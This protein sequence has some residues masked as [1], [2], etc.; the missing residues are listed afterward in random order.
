MKDTIE[1]IVSELNKDGFAQCHISELLSKKE[2]KKFDKLEDFYRRFRNNS[3]VKERIE[4]IAKGIPEKGI[5]KWYEIRANE[6]LGRKTSIGDP[7]IDLYSSEVFIKIAQNFLGDNQIRFRN[8]ISWIHPKTGLNK[9]INSQNWHRD[10]EDYKILKVFIALNNIEDENGPTEFIKETQFGGRFENITYNMRW[11]D[12]YLNPNIF[13]KIRNAYVKR[14]KRYKMRYNPPKEN[15][16]KATGVKGT[17]F[18]INSNGLHKG[19]FV[20]KGERFLTHACYLKSDAPMILYSKHKNFNNN[21]NKIN[22]NHPNY[23]KLSDDQ[24]QLFL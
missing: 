22:I 4:K 19:G 18:F 14:F 1:K 12:Y 23:T 2:L 16:I 5:L 20:K 13:K 8:V 9:Q 17:V 11:L 10:Q 7:D 15:F 6:F 3:L 21:V 24:K